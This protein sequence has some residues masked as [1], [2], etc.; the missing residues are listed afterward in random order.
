MPFVKKNDAKGSQTSNDSR[1]NI[2][3]RTG[4]LLFFV[5]NI[6]KPEDPTHNI[7]SISGQ[8]GVGKSTLLMQ[9]IDETH[10]PIF[11]D[12]CLTALVNERQVTPVSI[13]EKFAEQ[14]HFKDNLKKALNQYKESM[15]QLQA[16]R[17]APLEAFLGKMPELTGSIVKDVPFAGGILKEG[18]QA[19]S[20]F[21]VKKY[22]YHQFLK[23]AEQQEDPL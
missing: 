18:T 3:S 19:A 21:L 5:Q 17:E 6:L 7:I 1:K 16:E 20:E 11:R 4:E 12:Y 10:A 9:F 15:H 22:H 8:G 14:L 23:N 2:V 13:M